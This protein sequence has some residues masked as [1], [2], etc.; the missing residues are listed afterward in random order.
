[1]RHSSAPTKWD[2]FK[3]WANEKEDQLMDLPAM[4][5]V[6]LMFLVATVFVLALILLIGFVV[7]DS[8]VCPSGT[9]EI[10]ELSHYIYTSDVPIPVYDVVGCKTVGR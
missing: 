2:H 10:T 6:P 1:M 4:I 9:E 8:S 3:K 7:G 5:A